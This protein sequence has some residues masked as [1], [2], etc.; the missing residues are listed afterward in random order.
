[1]GVALA[2]ELQRLGVVVGLVVEV[3]EHAGARAPAYLLTVDLGPQGR[4][5]CSVPRGDYQQGELEDAQVVCARD[6]DEYVVL[7]AHSHAQ[8][9]VLLR[10]DRAIEPGSIVA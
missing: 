3:S 5:E 9:V 6:G 4:H 10:P 1:V 2:E 7:A 8:G